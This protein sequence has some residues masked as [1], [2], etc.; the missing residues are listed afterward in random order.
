[1]GKALKRMVAEFSAGASQVLVMAPRRDY[2]QPAKNGF[3][4]DHAQLRQDAKKVGNE[5]KKKL[6]LVHN[7]HGESSYQ[8]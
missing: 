1:M 4:A 6:K 2:V 7:S 5:L 3:A 8:R